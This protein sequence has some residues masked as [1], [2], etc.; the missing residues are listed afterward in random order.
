[1]GQASALVDETRPP[2]PAPLN[3]KHCRHGMEGA[4]A[5]FV[6]RGTTPYTHCPTTAHSAGA[7][8]RKTY[9][10]AV[11]FL[12]L[13]A[14]R[15]SSAAVHDARRTPRELKA[16]TR[17]EDDMNQD[18][19]DDDDL[20]EREYGM[21]KA[22]EGIWASYI[23]IF[24][25]HDN[26]THDMIE[27]E[28]NQAAISLCTCVF[29]D[30]RGEPYLIVGTVKDLRPNPKAAKGGALLTFRFTDDGTKLELVHK[31][32]LNGIPHALCPF[33]GRLLCGVDNVLRCSASSPLGLD[34][35]VLQLFGTSLR[36]PSSLPARHVLWERVCTARNHGNCPR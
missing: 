7:R 32:V 8:L 28:D 9:F 19:D 30:T 13:C 15:S 17:D 10:K 4:V 12:H 34:K 14:T 22:P 2:P 26:V 36:P 20:P 6:S 5:A 21:I 11:D 29:H 23:R 33:Q 25:S 35:Q 18:D 3:V 31:T 27:L 24:D 1:M 16:N